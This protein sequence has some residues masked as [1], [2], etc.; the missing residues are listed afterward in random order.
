MSIFNEHGIGQIPDHLERFA[1]SH[2]KKLDHLIETI[3]SA[4]TVDEY[5]RLPGSIQLDGSGNGTIPLVSG[6]GYG[7][8]LERLVFVVTGGATVGLVTV[9]ANSVSPGTVVE[10]ATGVAGNIAGIGQVVSYAD[11][12]A[13]N[14]YL[15]DQEQIVVQFSGYT[16]NAQAYV[17]I[18]TKLLKEPVHERHLSSYI[19]GE[20]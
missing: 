2:F 15:S 11:A 19:T 4:Q 18:Q 13:N 10:T 9:H 16:A 7:Q 8:R 5:K 1:E 14:I 12:F 6:Q 17:N 3:Q 20:Y